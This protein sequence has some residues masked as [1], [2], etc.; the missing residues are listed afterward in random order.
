MKIPGKELGIERK[1]SWN[2]NGKWSK[3]FEPSGLPF[4]R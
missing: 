3:E 4:E 1:G 2:S